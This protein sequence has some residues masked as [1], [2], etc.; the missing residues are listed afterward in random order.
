MTQVRTT[1]ACSCSQQVTLNLRVWLN[2]SWPWTQPPC[3]TMLML[4]G[5]LLPG[6]Y[7]EYFTENC[8][9]ARHATTRLPTSAAVVCEVP[10]PALTARQGCQHACAKTALVWCAFKARMLTIPVHS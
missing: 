3:C 10:I 8:W 6:L 7:E 9:P 2:M 4:D 5:L 1:V